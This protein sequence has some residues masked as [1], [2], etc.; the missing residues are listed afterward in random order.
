MTLSIVIL[1]DLLLE[2]PSDRPTTALSSLKR[3][4]DLQVL[5]D[6]SSSLA[7]VEDWRPWSGPSTQP[8]RATIDATLTVCNY[9]S[10]LSRVH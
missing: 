3:G 6:R 9:M 7:L 1:I 8:P 5:Y 10:R 4:W 2:M